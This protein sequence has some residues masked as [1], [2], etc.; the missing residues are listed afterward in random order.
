MD[1]FNPG[2]GTLHT[3]ISKTDLNFGDQYSLTFVPGLVVGRL[4]DLGY[5]RIPLLIS[6][7]VIVLA[8]FLTAQCQTYWQFLL[9]QGIAIGV[10]VSIYLNQFGFLSNAVVRLWLHLWA[11]YWCHF[12]LVQAEKSYGFRYH[13]RGIL[14]RRDTVS[15]NI[16]EFSAPDRVSILNDA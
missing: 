12:P 1:W 10:G 15:N 11:V 13:G 7:S 2:I 4:F 3:F 6:S 16:P 5:M 9:C 8:T 14:H